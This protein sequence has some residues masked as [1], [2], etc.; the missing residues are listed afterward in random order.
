[1]RPPDGVMYV[2]GRRWQGPPSEHVFRAL[3]ANWRCIGTQEAAGRAEADVRAV[4]AGCTGAFA[5]EL[6][7]EGEGSCRKPWHVEQRGARFH[8]G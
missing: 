4:W 8:I 3:V 6:R 5:F 2:F 1:M 7:G